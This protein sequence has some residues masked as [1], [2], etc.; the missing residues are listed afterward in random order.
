MGLA[1]LQTTPDSP[2]SR[3][4][5]RALLDYEASSPV[6]DKEDPGADARKHW[7]DAGTKIAAVQA[8]RAPRKIIHTID[9]F[10]RDVQPSSV[11]GATISALVLVGTAIYT[12]FLVYA[13][14]HQTPTQ[15]NLM[16][17]TLGQGPT[18]PINITCL[19]TSGCIISNAYP[20]AAAT[21]ASPLP[22]DSETCIH[23]QANESTSLHLL[24]SNDP[25]DGL[26][27]LFDPATTMPGY[28]PRSAVSVFSQT[29][30]YPNGPTCPS[31][32][33]VIALQVGPGLS[34]ASY[35]RTLNWTQPEDNQGRLR[36]EWFMSR[37]AEDGTLS[38]VE[39]ASRPCFGQ[40]PNATLASLQQARIRLQPFWNKIEVSQDGVWLSLWGTCG[41]A[42][43]T[44]LQVGTAL[45]V[46]MNFFASSYYNRRN[47]NRNGDGE[48]NGNA[49]P[50]A[51]EPPADKDH[52]HGGAGLGPRS[53]A[54]VTELSMAAITASVLDRARGGRSMKGDALAHR[55][56]FNRNH[57]VHPALNSPGGDSAAGGGTVP[58]WHAHT[59]PIATAS[60]VAD[61]QGFTNP[62]API[63]GYSR[64][65]ISTS[66]VVVEDFQ[67]PS[68]PSGFTRPSSRPASRG[69]SFRISANGAPSGGWTSAPMTTVSGAP[70]GGTDTPR[71]S[72]LAAVTPAVFNV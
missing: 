15:T 19:A 9:L 58:R 21:A 60:D 50:P 59:N 14:L 27:V 68:S 11:I 56:S 52:G 39:L 61:R 17:W 20:R 42:F 53:Y 43:S 65:A 35:V 5:E 67:P 28:P 30:C 18:F 25:D 32:I 24:W 55:P 4:S 64:G 23:L 45:V 3:Q 7:H 46:V 63:R 34:L 72:R 29:K 40:L 33:F 36:H 70:G 69:S 13:F 54:S 57:S 48:G 1:T 66:A 51:A 62:P 8:L 71:S 6:G 16:D 10:A 12:A 26:S 22:P 31:G 49:A 44:F 38:Q 47:G 2:A 37:V 41:G